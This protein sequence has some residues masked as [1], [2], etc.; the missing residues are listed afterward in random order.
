MINAALRLSLRAVD[1]DC[2]L[3]GRRRDSGLPPAKRIAARPPL[4]KLMKGEVVKTLGY[5]RLVEHVLDEGDPRE[6]PEP[7]FAGSTHTQ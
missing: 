7:P 2:C 1:K 6:Q 4:R 3:A 5:L